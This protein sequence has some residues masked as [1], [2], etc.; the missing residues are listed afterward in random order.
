MIEALV[1]LLK[2][3]GGCLEAAGPLEDGVLEAAVVAVDGVGLGSHFA[4]SSC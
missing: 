4:V 1:S 2:H 3:P